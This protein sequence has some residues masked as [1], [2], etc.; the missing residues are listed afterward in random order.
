MGKKKRAGEM[1]PAAETRVA[2]QARRTETMCEQLVTD[3]IYK[4]TVMQEY[5]IWAW[6]KLS[7][8][9]Q[10][11]ARS[12]VMDSTSSLSTSC[13]G[14][15]M[16]EVAHDMLI[17]SLGGTP[18]LSHSCE[19]IGFKR[20]HL[21]QTVHTAVQA[22][23]ACCFHEFGELSRGMAR[24]AVHN[25]LCRVDFSAHLAVIGYSC[26]DMSSLKHGSKKDVLASRTGS[27]GSTC[28]HLI[29]YLHAAKT[30][31]VILENVPEMAKEEHQSENVRYLAEA[32]RAA[33]Y[34]L[35]TRL[36]DAQEFMLPQRRKRAWTVLLQKEALGLSSAESQRV[37]HAIFQT[38]EN[39]KTRPIAAKKL[40]LKTGDGALEA[41]LRRRQVNQCEGNHF[42]SYQELHQAFMSR[43][44]V[45]WA[46]LRALP[47][48]EESAWFQLAPPREKDIIAFAMKHKPDLTSVDCSQRIDRC[49]MTVKGI[50]PTITPNAKHFLGFFPGMGGRP[51]NRFILG[52]ESLAFQGFP[53]ELLARTAANTSDRQ[54][55]DLAGNA[56]PSTCLLA[57][58][59]AML[60]HVP[61]PSLGDTQPDAP[62]SQASLAS[63]AD[64]LIDF[65][66]GVV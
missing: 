62:D 27:S 33:G 26:K 28:Q 66:G 64:S 16:T 7:E 8:Q 21:M 34:E 59:L 48:T 25:Q 2:K 38:V 30:K 5:L 60:V 44:G 17:R 32:A 6:T 43:K 22:E 24:C 45:S 65:L 47:S 56:F 54:Y 31:V 51:L 35:C 9:E 40:L 49:T 19:M 63:G 39:L 18:Y 20:E 52:V 12:A 4:G 61:P 41:E 15:G 37:L 36:L 50:L 55:Q 58:M 42:E 10:R 29:A 14:S 23:R 11:M 13:S 1:P 57:I 3:N 53:V 46:Q